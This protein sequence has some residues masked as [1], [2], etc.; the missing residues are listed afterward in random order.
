VAVLDGG[1]QTVSLQRGDRVGPH[2]LEAAQ[3]KAYTA[4]STQSS[5]L[6]FGRQL[7]GNPDTSALAHM[8]ELLL[9]G[10]GLPL[11]RGLDLIGA[12]GVAGGGGPEGD[13]GCARAALAAA[14]LTPEALN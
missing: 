10:G 8:P 12:V 3:R 7:R 4:L 6:A 14:G 11:W 13:E 9:I 1:A 2:N 5:T